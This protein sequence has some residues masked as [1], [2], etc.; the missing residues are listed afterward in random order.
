M[1]NK[2]RSE[3]KEKQVRV[4]HVIRGIASIL[5]VLADEVAIN[6]PEDVED[7]GKRA[8]RHLIELL[9][10][11]AKEMRELEERVTHLESI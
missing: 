2:V 1:T 3:M 9:E 4:T 11:Y 6:H 10:A 5:N 8:A 7:T